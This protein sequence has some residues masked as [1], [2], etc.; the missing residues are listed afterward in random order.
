MKVRTMKR[1]WM[2]GTIA[3]LVGALLSGALHAG[4]EDHEYQK[5]PH[6][7]LGVYVES[8]PNIVS[9]Q[10]GLDPDI[11]VVVEGLVPGGPAEKAGFEKHDILLK[12]GDQILIGT[13][14]IVV[15]VRNSEIGSKHKF[16]Y[17]R[18]G[19]EAVLE[20]ELGESK[21]K[22]KK[23]NEHGHLPVPV[24]PM[25]PTPPGARDV[26]ARALMALDGADENV[27]FR[28][29][30]DEI[31]I[32]E[33]MEF[34]QKMEV[35]MQRVNSAV[36]GVEGIA[37]PTVVI[38]DESQVFEFTDDSGARFVIVGS[39]DD[40]ELTIVSAEG[41]EQYRGPL[42][43]EAKKQLPEAIRGRLPRI[44]EIVMSAPRPQPPAVRSETVDSF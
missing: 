3:L 17:L 8:V 28:R 23:A 39:G 38:K 40:K 41:S 31:D 9:K 15:L 37:M 29:G 43:E 20:V 4:D 32:D 33:R 7:Y 16:T 26:V 14:Q 27:L 2:L 21:P 19:E 1:K 5:E 10:L 13:K 30:D 18:G 11:G 22:K 42:D 25:S 12:F 36:D 24:A 44:R 6:A 35:L 34:N